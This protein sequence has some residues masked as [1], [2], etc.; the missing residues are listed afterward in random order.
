MKINL[1]LNTYLRRL[2]FIASRN[3]QSLITR[4]IV[5]VIFAGDELVKEVDPWESWLFVI[6]ANE[7]IK[8]R[9]NSQ[10]KLRG[11][12]RNFTSTNF[13]RIKRKSGRKPQKPVFEGPES[14]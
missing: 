10:S 6:A 12:Q 9:E 11:N 2:N 14:R 3:F 4:A 5:S 13:L 8:G 7:G 1:E